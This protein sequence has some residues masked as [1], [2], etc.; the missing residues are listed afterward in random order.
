MGYEV[1]PVDFPTDLLHPH[2]ENGRVAE[3]LRVS[4]PGIPP[5]RTM[6]HIAARA[7]IAMRAAA[8]SEANVDL[9]PSS[10]GDLYRTFEDQET[11]FRSRYQ[12]EPILGADTKNWRNQVWY[13]KDPD[14]LSLIHI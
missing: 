14:T 7:F 11:L 8:K 4:I 12:L 1:R 13:K 10:G 9:Q 5:A 2:Q 3:E 6:H